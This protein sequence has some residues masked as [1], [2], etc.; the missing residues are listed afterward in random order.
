M[1]PDRRRLRA[2]NAFY[3][4]REA[5]EIVA[6]A[7]TGLFGGRSA[8]V[9][10]FG[11]E[12]VVLLHM[13]AVADPEAPVL[14]VDTEMLFAETL[15]YQQEIAA[16]LGLS[17]IVRI[18][19][20][21][22]DLA[23]EDPDGALHRADH[24]ACCGLRKVRPLARALTGWDVLVSG[25]KRYQSD[26]RAGLDLFEQD[27][28]GRLKVN[29]LADW[30]RDR[31][32]SYMDDHALPRHPLVARGFHSLGCAPCT[33]PVGEGEDPRAGRWRGVDKVECGIHFIDGRVV[34]DPGRENAA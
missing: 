20:D 6:H 27:G 18:T 28:E 5:T 13:W 21:P 22:A 29:P 31:T 17:N 34:R 9:S 10:S 12:S 4:G 7:A 11:A 1:Q 32:L 30:S 26:T 15:A 16:R 25:R 3:A 8:L 23:A 14:F 19:P 33:T 2:L 24:D